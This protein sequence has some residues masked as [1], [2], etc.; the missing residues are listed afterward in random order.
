MLVRVYR[1]GNPCTLLVGMYMGVATVENSMEVS[2]KIKNRTITW[3]RNST[4][5]YI[6][7]ETNLTDT[8]TPMFMAA[9]FTIA[10]MEVT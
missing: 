9:L 5:G 7:K 8:Y 1:K 10:N 3:L 6:S 2:Q 4:P